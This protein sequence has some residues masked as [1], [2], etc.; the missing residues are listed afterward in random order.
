[1]LAVGV[2]ALVVE[3]L[4]F[5]MGFLPYRGMGAVMGVLLVAIGSYLKTVPEK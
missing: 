5:V 1:M 4:N 2:V 3:T